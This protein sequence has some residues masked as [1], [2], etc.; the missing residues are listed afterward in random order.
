MLG[1]VGNKRVIA[2]IKPEVKRL[3]EKPRSRCK[4]NNDKTLIIE[5]VN[6]SLVL[7]ICI[8]KVLVSNTA[9]ND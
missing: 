6:S 7:Q 8:Q 5:Q 2:S 4:N 1:G 9:Y 3:P